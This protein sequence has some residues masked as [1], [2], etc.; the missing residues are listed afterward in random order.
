PAAAAMEIVE[1]CRRRDLHLN[2]YADDRLLMSKDG[3]WAEFYR[4]HTGSPLEIR[5]GLRGDIPPR[6][7]KLIIIDRGEV[8]V[9]LESE[10]RS[11]FVGIL[12]ITRT[13]PE[14]LEFMARGTTKA[15]ALAVVA[16]K[17]GIPRCEVAALGD[18]RNDVEM[19]RW[20]G[21]GIA[22]CNGHPA[23]IASAAHHCGPN[24]LHGAAGVIRSYAEGML[25]SGSRRSMT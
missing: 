5:P 12:E 6:P 19:L 18:G 17:L 7:T 10:L 20:A 4:S 13:N 1:V 21:I 16:D 23:A 22:M 8:T 14:Y 24:Y 15:R 11:R 2:Y 3:P 25:S 9:R